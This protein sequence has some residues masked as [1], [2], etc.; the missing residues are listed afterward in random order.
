[1]ALSD[2]VNAVGYEALG[3]R[4]EVPDEIVDRV[5]AIDR[6]EQTT[7]EVDRRR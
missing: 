1:M 4:L 6:V 5:Q 7:G 3:H 2:D